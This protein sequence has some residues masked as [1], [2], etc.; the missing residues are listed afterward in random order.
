MGILLVDAQRL[1]IHALI[2]QR[3]LPGVR[4]ALVPLVPF[5]V[6]PFDVVGGQLLRVHQCCRGHRAVAVEA[7][8]VFLL[9][10]GEPDL[11]AHHGDDRIPDQTIESQTRDMEHVTSRQDPRQ[12]RISRQL[13]DLRVIDEIARRRADRK[14]PIGKK[15]PQ[16][17]AV[18]GIVSLDPGIRIAPAQKMRLHRLLESERGH[19]LIRLIVQHGVERMIGSAL[20]AAG[21]QTLVGDEGNLRDRL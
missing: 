16:P 13:L 21:F 1:D 12:A 9:R 2:Q 8:G 3:H 17:D 18:S 19:L 6:E 11:L 20:F 14:G 10:L 4:H 7:A 5:G 15:R